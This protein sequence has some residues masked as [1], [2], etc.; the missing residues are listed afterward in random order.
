[1]LH[2]NAWNNLTRCW[3]TYWCKIAIPERIYCPVGWGCRIHRLHFCR[4]VWSPPNECP[5]YD[6]KQSDGEAPVMPELWGMLS[7]PSMPSLPSPL[8]PGVVAPGR[9]LSMSQ[10]ELNCILVL[11]LI[12]WIRT[13]WLN[14]IA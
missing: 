7:A 4:G 2:N 14:W 13:F 6:T 5:G 8:R 9:A 1:M 12:V 3:W 10:I 11:N